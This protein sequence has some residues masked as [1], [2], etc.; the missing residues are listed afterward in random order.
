MNLEEIIKNAHTDVSYGVVNIVIK[1]H[2]GKISTVDSDKNITYKT[3][4]GNVEGLT[5]IGTIIKKTS[6]ALK[7]RPVDNPPTLTFTVFYDRKGE[8]RQINVNDFNRVN[9]K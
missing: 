9:L 7:L 4:R 6:E 2:A 8:I 5:V 3:E 1:K